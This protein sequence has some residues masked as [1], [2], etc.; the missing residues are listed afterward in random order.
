MK[1]KEK[2]KRFVVEIKDDPQD[3]LRL[4]MSFRKRMWRDI[5]R[6]D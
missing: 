4:W 2:D 5:Y 1:K 3:K 6:N